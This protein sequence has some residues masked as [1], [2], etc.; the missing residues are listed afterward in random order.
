M[1]SCNSLES[2]RTAHLRDSSMR[3]CGTLISTFFEKDD[4][5][6]SDFY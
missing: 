3:Y 4:F 6:Q 5:F 2:C 1:M